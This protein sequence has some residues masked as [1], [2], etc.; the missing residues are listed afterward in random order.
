MGFHEVD[1]PQDIAYG[2]SGG[3]GFSTEIVVTDSGKEQRIANWSQPRHRFNAAYAIRSYAQ[4]QIVKT[5]YNAR[6]GP[7][8][9]FRFKDWFDFTTHVD[10]KSA[11]TNADAKI[12]DGNGTIKQFQLVKKYSSGLQDRFHKLRKPVAATVLIAFDTGGGPVDQPSG[13]TFDTTTGLVTFTTEPPIGTSVY[14]GCEFDKPVR[15]GEDI[16]EALNAQYENFGSGS[17]SDIPL[18]EL[19]DEEPFSDEFYYGGSTLLL[20]MAASVSIS[21]LSGK[22]VIVD[23][24]VSG[25]S[26]FLPDFTNLPTGGPWFYLNNISTGPGDSVS[27]RDSDDVEVG[28]LAASSAMEI[29]LGLITSVNKKWYGLT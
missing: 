13:W 5:F 2:T 17:I 28:I 10:G 27:I 21:E 22:V 11:H 23:P 25:L 6:L 18:I 20:A 12:G 7:A 4:L 24:T 8:N 26:L 9:G 19:V 15:F 1:F 29:W 14:A 3:P 16:D